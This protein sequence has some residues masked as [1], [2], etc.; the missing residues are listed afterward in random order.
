MKISES[1]VQEATKK[2]EEIKTNLADAGL[3]IKIH[4]RL[5]RPPAEIIS[6]SDT[7]AISLILS[8]H[9]KVYWQRFSSGAPRLVSPSTLTDPWWTSVPQANHGIKSAHGLFIREAHSVHYHF[10]LP[11]FHGNSS[12]SQTLAWMQQ[13]TILPLL[14]CS[15]S[16]SPEIQRNREFILVIYPR[17]TI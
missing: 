11:R 13:Y 16:A 8:S 17:K 4:I 10:P 12:M 3:S 5:V 9:G 15:D 7:E 14:S 1:N 2:P 6:L